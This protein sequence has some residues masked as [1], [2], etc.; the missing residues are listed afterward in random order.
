M[1]GWKRD[2]SGCRTWEELPKEAR[3][4]VEFVEK[5]IGCHITY[6]SVGPERYSI[7]IR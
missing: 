5:Q 3:D 6:V 4:Y 1:P 7:I 2:I